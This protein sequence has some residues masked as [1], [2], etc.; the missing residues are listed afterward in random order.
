VTA[1]LLV[2]PQADALAAAWRR[3]TRLR[4]A[5]MLVRDRAED[6]VPSQGVPLL[7]VGRALGYPAAVDPGRVLDDYRRTARR[8]RRVVEDVF[9]GPRD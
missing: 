7:A 6:Q 4:N 1:G 2:R 8:A 9:Y 5:I 3:A